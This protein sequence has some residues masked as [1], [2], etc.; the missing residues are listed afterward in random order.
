M[1]R[2]LS[3][4]DLK[5]VFAALMDAAT[6]VQAFRRSNDD[7]LLDHLSSPSSFGRQTRTAAPTE[8]RPLV[9]GLGPRTS[10]AILLSEVVHR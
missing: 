1:N 3:Q 7:P 8:A 2:E 9:A 4:A 10:F 5:T 6:L